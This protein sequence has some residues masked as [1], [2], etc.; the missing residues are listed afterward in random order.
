MSAERLCHMIRIFIATMNSSDFTTLNSLSLPPSN[1]EYD[2][3]SEDEAVGR[4]R[5]RRYFPGD[6]E[7]DLSKWRVQ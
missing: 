7:S 3:H 1:D 4:E 2:T 5:S 6:I